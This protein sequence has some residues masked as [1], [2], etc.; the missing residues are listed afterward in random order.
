LI[1]RL[2]N[3]RHRE[4]ILEWQ[5]GNNVNTAKQKTAHKM[6]LLQCPKLAS[7]QHSA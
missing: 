7:A 3:K 6:K 2:Q 1:A 5:L 4:Q